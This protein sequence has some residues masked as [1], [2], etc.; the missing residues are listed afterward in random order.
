MGA[1]LSADF[2]A[3]LARAGDDDFRRRAVCPDPRPD[4]GR[5]RVRERR[6]RDASASASA[7]ATAFEISE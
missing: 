3:G 7:M 5:V 1:G 2:D 6:L 4:R